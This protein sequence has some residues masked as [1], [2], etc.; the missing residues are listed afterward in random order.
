MTVG[1]DEVLKVGLKEGVKV[2]MNARANV[3]ANVKLR[4][5]QE[6]FCEAYAVLGNGTQ[7]A[8][9]AGYSAR[10][11][12]VQACRLLG[13][14][15]VRARVAVLKAELEARAGITSDYVLMQA[16]RVFERCMGGVPVVKRGE[17]E[18]DAQGNAVYAFDVKGALAALE[19]IGKHGAVGAFKEKEKRGKGDKE[20]WDKERLG[21]AVEEAAQAQEGEVK[22]EV[23]RGVKPVVV[24]SERERADRV[25][26]LLAL[27]KARME[28]ENGGNG[29]DNGES[30]GS[31]KGEEGEVVEAVVEDFVEREGEE[32]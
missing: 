23:E 15:E 18:C 5:R 11:A 26:K 27:A 25:S 13:C 20:K 31:E 14:A 32:A 9:R 6:A 24:M 4:A 17:A 30:E 3:G 16:V 12:Q 28:E 21:V 1:L 29:G 10:T 22:R 2:G 8:I 7:A 19:L